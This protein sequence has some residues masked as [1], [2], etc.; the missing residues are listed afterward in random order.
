MRCVEGVRTL[1]IGSSALGTGSHFT[2]GDDFQRSF[3]WD[4]TKEE[5]V[6]RLFLLNDHFM[7]LPTLQYN[8][9]G[10]IPAIVQDAKSRRVLMMAWMNTAS[11]EA[12]MRTGLMNYWS[13]S[14]K[15]F[16]I[17][18][19]TSGH[20]Q[21][22][23]RWSADCDGDT[24]LF[25]VEQVGGACHTGYESC[26]FQAFTLEGRAEEIAEGKVFD[27]EKAYEVSKA[28]GQ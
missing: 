27:P 12:T 11:L 14:R 15:K 22:V 16:W 9:D 23:I 17:K 10:L 19:E 28:D 4:G 7:Q 20:S 8:A 3:F 18:G 1:K 25:E 21:K 5:I 24:L 13:R 2:L 26:F 6:A